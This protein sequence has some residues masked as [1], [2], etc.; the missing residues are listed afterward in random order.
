MAL[1]PS[2]RVCFFF[3]SLWDLLTFR[4]YLFCMSPRE[5]A[6]HLVKVTVEARTVEIGRPG[7]YI[8]HGA[9]SRW[10]LMLSS[11]PDSGLGEDWT[12]E[13]KEARTVH[14]KASSVSHTWRRR[15]IYNTFNQMCTVS[16][17]CKNSSR[18]ALH[19][20]GKPCIAISFSFL[21]YIWYETNAGNFIRYMQSVFRVQTQS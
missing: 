2:V 6:V 1:D 15:R 18:L 13:D 12:Q 10:E 17:T 8:R 21:Q 3:F 4:S 5:A 11:W 20:I 16:R 7:K 14:V 9:P 19:N